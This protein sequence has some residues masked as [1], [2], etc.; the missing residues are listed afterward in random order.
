M[1]YTALWGYLA[2]YDFRKHIKG[3][4]QCFWRAGPDMSKWILQVGR[5][6]D[7]WVLKSAAVLGHETH[8]YIQTR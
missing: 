6:P 4:D 8:E 7:M 2:E 1:A 5:I 3:C